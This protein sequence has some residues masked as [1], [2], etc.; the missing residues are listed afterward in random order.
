MASVYCVVFP[1]PL[2]GGWGER[3]AG[4]HMS[5]VL[6]SHPG[7][8]DGEVFMIFEIVN[9]YEINNFVSIS[10]SFLYSFINCLRHHI[11]MFHSLIAFSFI[12]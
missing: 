1:Q 6:V 2:C 9:F 7:N 4:V 8:T 11:L 12:H 3:L 10:F 5:L